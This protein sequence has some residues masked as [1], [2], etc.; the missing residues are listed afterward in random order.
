MTEAQAA[1]AADAP[2]TVAGRGAYAL[3]APLAVAMLGLLAYANAFGGAFVFDDVKHVRDNPLVRD[4]G[5]YLGSLAG[6]RALPNR[7]VGY[8][9]FALNHRLGGTSVAGYHAFNVAVHVLNALLVYV[10]VRSTFRSPRLEGS[11]LAPQ[12]RA[13]AFAAAA[14]FV[15]HPLQT[16][17]VTYVVQRLT[18]L[19]TFF[20]LSAVV[21]YARWRLAGRDAGSLRRAGT[22]AL[23]LAA[24][25]L[26]MRT[27][28]IAFTLP[29]A[30]LL[31]ELCFFERAGRSGWALAPLLATA[32]IVPL[33][34]LDLGRP[35]AEVLADAGAVTQ[36]QTRLGRLEYATTQAPVVVTYLFLLLL[37]IGQ[38]LDHDY[39]IYRSLLAPE[40][41][42]AIAVLLA[43]AGAGAYLHLRAG[44]GGAR[45]VDPAGRL[46]AFGIAWWFL[47]LAVE[48]SFVPIVDVI[49]EHRAYLPSVGFFVAA[50]VAIAAAA[51]RAGDARAPRAVFAAA[52]ALALLLAVATRARNEVWRGEISLW[53]DAAA[54]SPGKARPHLNLGTALVEAGRL[55]E[56]IRPLRRAVELDPELAWARAQLGGALLALGRPSEAEPELRAALR[57]APE[58]PEAT[59]NL[60]QLVWQAGNRDEGRRWFARF[61]EIA[62]ASYASAREVAARRIAP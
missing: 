40:V 49:N 34:L 47:A 43:I 25:L 44:R 13:I 9:T 56:A 50:A 58:D 1:T 61:L 20:Y 11:A 2:R 46:A 51:R 52:A 45:P 29:F 27:K 33:T 28:E 8:L 26:A 19:A 12:A 7:Y 6:Y 41:L 32:A 42:S 53:S 38:N 4:L 55:P 15:A 24:A 17:A 36:V 22:W 18:S 37:P 57:L 5:N 35:A 16:Q 62:P 54:K 48:S 21:A 59:F 30:I 39:P 60:A 31:Y 10:L 3:A 14:L 23:A